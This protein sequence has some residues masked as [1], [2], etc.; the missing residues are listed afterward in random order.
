MGITAYDVPGTVYN[1]D[2]TM[3]E[4]VTCLHEN[5]GLIPGTYIYNNNDNGTVTVYQCPVP[6]AENDL[7]INTGI[8]FES[9]IMEDIEKSLVNENRLCSVLMKTTIDIINRKMLSAEIV[10]KNSIY[11]S[12]HREFHANTYG[13]TVRCA[14]GKKYFISAE[15]LPD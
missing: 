13:I 6:Y 9:K 12:I 5:F 2:G 14:N 7:S 1:A 4:I 3:D 15:I 10:Q 11:E 8:D